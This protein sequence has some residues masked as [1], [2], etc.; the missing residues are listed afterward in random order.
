MCSEYILSWNIVGVFCIQI[1]KLKAIILTF[2]VLKSKIRKWRF[3]RKD[4]VHTCN[5]QQT[6]KQLLFW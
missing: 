4:L 2:S 3:V 5:W 1:L 6:R